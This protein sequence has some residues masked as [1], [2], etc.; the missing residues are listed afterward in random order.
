MG[1][2]RSRRDEIEQRLKA[3]EERFRIAQ[4]TGGIGWFEWDLVTDAWECTPH[5]AIS[6]R[7]RR[8]LCRSKYRRPA[9]EPVRCA[10]RL[11]PRPLSIGPMRGRFS[12]R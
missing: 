8:P 1:G 5:V 11:E 10:A 9:R 4:V 2:D 12:T 6:K 7:W 3:T